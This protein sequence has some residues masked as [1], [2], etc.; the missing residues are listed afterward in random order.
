MQPVQGFLPK[1]ASV[2]VGMV[3]DPK[4]SRQAQ[5]QWS[6]S[7]TARQREEVVEDRYSGCNQEADDAHAR[8]A[9][10]PCAPMHSG[11]GLKMLRLSQDSHEHVLR[12]DVDV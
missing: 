5:C 9:S 4:P 2:V 1:I 10:E 3:I 6:E 8:H 12:T 7:D 11:I